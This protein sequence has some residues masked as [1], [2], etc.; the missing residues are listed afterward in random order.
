MTLL[1]AA[2][3]GPGR[4]IGPMMPLGG[5]RRVGIVVEVVASTS[6]AR[7]L[8]QRCWNRTSRTARASAD[9][10]RANPRVGVDP[11]SY[12]RSLTGEDA[13]LRHSPPGPPAPAR[14]GAPPA[15]A[16]RCPAPARTR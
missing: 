10:R 12:L 9:F 5:L 2:R 3:V 4:A 15:R 6:Y 7:R 16:S 14:A 8:P 13:L 11:F 1:P